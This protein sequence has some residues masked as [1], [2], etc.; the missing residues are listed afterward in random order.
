MAKKPLA[1]GC[2]VAYETHFNCKATHSASMPITAPG[3]GSFA[4]WEMVSPVAQNKKI[5][6]KPRKMST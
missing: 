4:N 2:I 6:N 1:L 5:R 3:M